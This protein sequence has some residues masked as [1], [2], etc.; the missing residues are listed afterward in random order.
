METIGSEAFCERRQHLAAK[1]LR[2]DPDREEEIVAA[3][4]PVG[5][6]GCQATARD[7]AVEMGMVHQG[8]APGVQHGDEADS[9]A[10]MLRVGGDGPEG[11]CGGSEQGAV[12]FALVV[13]RQRRQLCRQ[14]EDDVEIGDRQQILAAVFQ[15][16]GALLRLALR[17]VAIAAGV[18]RYAYFT[19]AI[20][21]IDVA[22]KLG[23]TTGCE[24]AQDALPGLRH[25]QARHA[26]IGSGQ[27]TDDVG[28]LERWLVH[29]ELSAAVATT[30]VDSRSR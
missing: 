21:G 1:E 23:G 17:T 5:T 2:E 6:V 3:G 18:V 29:G 8:L 15:P 16:L 4:Y 9:S 30:P 12:D 7:D 28:D 14:G 25:P 19:T 10:E 27:G 24:I 13:Q 20:A 22:A 26:T 11:S